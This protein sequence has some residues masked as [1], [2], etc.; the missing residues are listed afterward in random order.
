MS[1]YW[2][3]TS[4]QGIRELYV[5]QKG[6]W[7][8]DHRYAILKSFS[9]W[10]VFQ[11]SCWRMQSFFLNYDS[12]S[13]HIIMA[14]VHS[15]FPAKKCLKVGSNRT[16]WFSIFISTILASCSKELEE[17]I[18]RYAARKMLLMKPLEKA[19]N[20]NYSG[21]Q[22]LLDTWLGWSATARRLEEPYT[23]KLQ[24]SNN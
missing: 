8:I 16:H 22:W 11:R 24:I 6:G 5:R 12:M 2:E 20:M 18:V 21:F 7:P 9:A 4:Y 14:W 23:Q 15:T 10:R 19:C 1:R 17:K 3:N 13:W